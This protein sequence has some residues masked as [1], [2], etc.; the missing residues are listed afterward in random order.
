MA[1]SQIKE[2]TV[3]TDFRLEQIYV[4]NSTFQ[5]RTEKSVWG[6]KIYRA[7]YREKL[8]KYISNDELKLALDHEWITEQRITPK[9]NS[10][11]HVVYIYMGEEMPQRHWYKSLIVAIRKKFRLPKII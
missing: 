4:L 2:K 8:L 6:D 10:T 11:Q 3:I 5:V 7:M 9:G 1:N